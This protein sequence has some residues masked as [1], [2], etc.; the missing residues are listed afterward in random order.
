M[1][2]GCLFASGGSS[3]TRQPPADFKEALKLD[4][5]NEAAKQELLKVQEALKHIPVTPK[6]V[7]APSTV[8]WFRHLRIIVLEETYRHFTACPGYRCAP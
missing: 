7:R 3:R 6:T 2:I 4:P 1:R 8:P 5:S